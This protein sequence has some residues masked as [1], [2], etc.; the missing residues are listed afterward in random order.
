[1][2]SI[3]N[4]FEHLI[5]SKFYTHSCY[6]L[7]KSYVVM[8]K[9]WIKTNS[10]HGIWKLKH[11]NIQHAF[12]THWK[13]PRRILLCTSFWGNFSVHL[14]ILSDI[15]QANLKIAIFNITMKQMKISF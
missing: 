7:V 6:T 12:D 3:Y 4:L 1:M 11:P 2:N 9:K 15:Y 13:N 10:L 8:L 5:T 14:K